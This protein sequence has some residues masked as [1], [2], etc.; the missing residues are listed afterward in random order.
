MVGNARTFLIAW[1]C[2]PSGCYLVII[3]EN[4][5]T[6]FVRKLEEPLIECEL[7][8][9]YYGTHDEILCYV[10]TYWRYSSWVAWG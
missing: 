5:L 10:S 7:H 9:Q 6:I 2:M 8:I 4:G 3:C 1:T